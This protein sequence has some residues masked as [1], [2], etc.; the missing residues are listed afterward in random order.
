MEPVLRIVWWTR[1]NLSSGGTLWMDNVF[2]FFT[3]ARAFPTQN[4]YAKYVKIR[5]GKTQKA[6]LHTHNNC[7]ND[8]SWV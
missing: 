2:V 3:A 7:K 8:D 1:E 4:P 6:M 5:C